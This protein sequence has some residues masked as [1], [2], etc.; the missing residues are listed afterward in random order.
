MKAGFSHVAFYERIK[1]NNMRIACLCVAL[2]TFAGCA[3]WSQADVDHHLLSDQRVCDANVSNLDS[4]A[5][6]HFTCSGTKP[7]PPECEKPDSDDLP[8]C[9]EWVLGERA[10][11][12]ELNAFAAGAVLFSPT[13]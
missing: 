5:R 6:K 10:R 1:S 3:T 13:P 11:L 2:L 12:D 8:A 4:S 9:R 7:L